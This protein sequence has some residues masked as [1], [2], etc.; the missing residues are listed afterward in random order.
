MLP[1]LI[2]GKCITA[3]AVLL[4]VTTSQQAPRKLTARAPEPMGTQGRLPSRR[5]SRLAEGP[6]ARLRLD[7]ARP[8]RPRT[9]R[10]S[11][12]TLPHA[13]HARGRRRRQQRRRRWRRREEQRG[14]VWS[15]A[16]GSPGLGRARPPAFPRARPPPAAAAPARPLTWV[17]AAAPRAAAETAAPAPLAGVTTAGA[18]GSSSAPSHW[19]RGNGRRG[20]HWLA[21]GSGGESG[22]RRAGTE[23]RVPCTDWLKGWSEDSETSVRGQ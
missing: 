4:T 11:G 3:D 18:A 22:V 15:N 12:Q 7:Q 9:L 6:E 23:L 16:T 13:A 5:S 21:G 14:P 1:F 17:T 10:G 2:N 8:D 20:P 19:R